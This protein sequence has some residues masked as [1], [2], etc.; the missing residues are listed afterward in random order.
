MAKMT[1][2]ELLNKMYNCIT[3]LKSELCKDKLFILFVI[4]EFVR[5]YSALESGKLVP[6]KLVVSNYVEF[7]NVLYN[8][9]NSFA[10]S[11]D[12]YELWDLL[13]SLS[14]YKNEIVEL[15]P[16]EIKYKILNALS[17]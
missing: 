9:R 17:I 14:A 15:F 1:K 3:I 13:E 6:N 16:D 11:C 8:Y 4:A 2:E 7:G 10:H 12:I 5:Y